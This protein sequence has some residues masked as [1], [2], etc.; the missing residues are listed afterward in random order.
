MALSKDELGKLLKKL[1]DQYDKYALKYNAIWFNVDAFEE[2]F[3]MAQDNR[4]NL[5]G[6]I[7]AEIS[8]FEKIK[9][10][11]NKKKKNK[12]FSD[13]VDKII[14][15]NYAKITKYP[16]KKFHKNAS[17]EIT[18]FYG[19]MF[20]FS[21]YYFG[22]LW[23]LIKDNKIKSII[24]QYEFSL[25]TLAV[26]QRGSEPKRIQD[27]MLVLSRQDVTELEIEKSRNNYLKESAFVLHDIIDFCDNLITT[28]N[29]EWETPLRFNDLFVEENKKKNMID[30]FSQCTGYGAI[31][32]VKE[33][34][35]GI[36]ENFRLGAFREK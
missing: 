34:A 21:E 28:K 25:Q 30:I 2:R 23:H 5:E 8:N 24:D 11:Y 29:P 26:P 20:E 9:E 14:E 1:R 13:K 12:T 4:M 16:K 10:K 3:K 33:F 6:F 18:Y 17:I 27:H 15:D 22:I 32:K 19:A 31:L 7:L 36:I 35:S